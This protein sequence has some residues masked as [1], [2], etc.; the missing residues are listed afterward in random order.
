VAQIEQIE[1]AEYNV[2]ANAILK[3]LDS[4]V[5]QY[6]P[7]FM[8]YR[9]KALAQM[10]GVSGVCAKAAVDALEV[11]RARLSFPDIDPRSVGTGR[12]GAREMDGWNSCR[13][14]I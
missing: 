5:N 13:L 7:T 3:V 10:P 9:E 2:A 12:R 4:Y 14:E 11:T 8:G 1:Q 6:V